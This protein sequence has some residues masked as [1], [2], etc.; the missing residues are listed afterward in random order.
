MRLA[1]F[2]VCVV[3]ALLAGWLNGFVSGKHR[4]KIVVPTSVEYRDVLIVDSPY[5][6]VA[7]GH[8]DGNLIINMIDPTKAHDL[9]IVAN[10]FN[11][12]VLNGKRFDE[13]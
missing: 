11:C 12:A 5:S 7:G 10:H 2:A 6:N 9:S 8:F 13:Q 4:A 3:M 1:I